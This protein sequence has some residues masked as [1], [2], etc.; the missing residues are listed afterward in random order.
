MLC[1]AELA[2][3][4]GKAHNGAS[5]RVLTIYVNEFL[6]N[7]LNDHVCFQDKFHSAISAYVITTP[8]RG[9]ANINVNYLITKYVTH[10]EVAKYNF[11]NDWTEVL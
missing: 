11:V 5:M 10:Q 4:T 8:D 3:D 2:R 7:D 6:V 1:D 9:L